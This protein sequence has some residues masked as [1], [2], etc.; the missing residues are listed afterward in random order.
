MFVCQPIANTDTGSGEQASSGDGFDGKTRGIKKEKE[1][2]ERKKRKKLKL[3]LKKKKKKKKKKTK[4]NETRGGD[5][6]YSRVSRAQ[7][8][9]CHRRKRRSQR[10]RTL[11]ILGSAFAPR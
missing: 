1:R 11:G 9:K 2:K 3:K 4:R 10:Q 5:S 8:S 7:P 6:T